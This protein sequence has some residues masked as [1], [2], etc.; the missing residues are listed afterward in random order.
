VKYLVCR[1]DA[2]KPNQQLS[3]SLFPI[4]VDGFPDDEPE[5]IVRRALDTISPGYV[6]LHSYLVVP[7]DNAEVVTFRPKPTYEVEVKRYL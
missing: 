3:S 7:M 4:V 2:V 5:Y 1:I 6:G